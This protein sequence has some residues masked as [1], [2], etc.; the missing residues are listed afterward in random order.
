MSFRQG[1][2]VGPYVI[3]RKLGAGG[4]ASVWLAHDGRRGQ[5]VAIKVMAHAVEPQSQLAARFLDEIRHHTLLRHP[6]IVAVRDVFSVGGQPCFV[7]DLAP[8]G[9]LAALLEA[10]G[11]R[12]LSVNE[13][14]PLIGEVLEALDYAHRQGMVHRDVKPSN[15]LLDASKQHALLS[16]F[17]I[18]LA[19]GERRRTRAG[20]SVGTAAYM[21]PEQIRA[22]GTIDF[23]SDVYSAGCVLYEL[24]TGRPPF[25]AGRAGA[26]AADD[27]TAR[28]EV[29]GMHLTKQPVPPHRRV[30]AIPRNVSELIMR[31][32]EKDPARRVPGC[33][34]FKR[35]LNAPAGWRTR[36]P[37][38]LRSPIGIAATL[39]F[40]AAAVLGVMA[41]MGA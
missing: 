40:A 7:M 32:L 25:V 12:R 28:A 10:R 22:T 39:A 3:E 23:R 18:A 41:V 14:L 1:Q 24:L 16:D 33:A 19:A 5:N 21:S 37:E 34:E 26:S 20:L 36:V 4:M 30:P 2:R 6:G 35:L 31:A 38:W 27:A 13:A 29:L 8:G 9:S 17:G 11:G 15:V